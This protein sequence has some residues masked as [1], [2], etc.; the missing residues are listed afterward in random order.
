MQIASTLKS[1]SFR[2]AA[3]YAALFTTSVLVL[4]AVIYVLVTSQLDSEFDAR[5]AGEACPQVVV[6]QGVHRL[7]KVAVASRTGE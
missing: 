3:A 4:A 1:A 6:A 7:E 2:L 5:V